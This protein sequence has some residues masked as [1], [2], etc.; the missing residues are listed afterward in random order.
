MCEN[1]E[2]KLT[3]L[4]AE[5]YLHVPGTNMVAAWEA[6][7]RTESTGGADMPARKPEDRST[8]TVVEL[9]ARD[10]LK[11]YVRTEP[12]EPL[13]I[14]FARW[15]DANMPRLNPRI[16]VPVFFLLFT[17]LVIWGFVQWPA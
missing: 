9:L 6:Y 15:L 8:S 16:V 14:R 1:P 2:P 17:A 5:N 7:W 13:D 11:G 10:L 3:I 12:P 4:M